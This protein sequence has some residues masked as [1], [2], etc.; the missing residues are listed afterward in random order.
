MMAEEDSTDPN[1][2]ENIIKSLADQLSKEIHK[3]AR[4]EGEGL[5]CY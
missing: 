2:P 4:A 3:S 5:S 1:N